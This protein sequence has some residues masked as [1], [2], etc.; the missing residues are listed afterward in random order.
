MTAGVL[1]AD[2][3]SVLS[4]ELRE[5]CWAKLMAFVDAA[6]ADLDHVVYPPTDQVFAA[7]A[8]SSYAATRVVIV[9]Q[10]PYHGP[11][12]AHGLSFSVPDDVPRRPPSLVNIGREL[13]DDEGVQL[14]SGNLSGWARQ[15]VLLLN[16]TLTVRAGK[17]GSHR[18]QGWETFT[19]AVIRA[20]DK[21][22]DR[23]VFILWGKDAQKKRGL[24]RR[25]PH[26]VIESSHPS[27][28]S[29]RLSFFGSKPFSRTNRLLEA[30]GEPP[31]DWSA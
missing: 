31:I 6:R 1:P 17:A 26:E 20:V 11:G 24:V 18:R 15:G 14:S 7:F 16:T 23:V 4:A 9:G 8:L 29:A 21:K 10:D 27:P 30:A 3:A 2:W 25:P 13:E 28:F 19:D 22:E 5:P 12:Q